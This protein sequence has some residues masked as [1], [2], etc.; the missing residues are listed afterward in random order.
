MSSYTYSQSFTETHAKHLAAKV[1]TD[2]KRMQRFYGSPSDFKIDQFEKEI[3]SFLKSGY[4]E[5]VTYGFKRNNK[6]I[7]PTLKYTAKELANSGV[8]DD[9]G[10]IRPGADISGAFFYSYLSQS[11]AYF[12]ASSDEQDKFNTNLPFQRTGADYPNTDGYFS[13]DRSYF[14][15]GKG[16]DR[17]SLKSF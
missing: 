16:L 8:D 4:L 1:A 17:S 9:P 7:E 6:W 2:L 10:K 15:G 13:N 14:S 12:N 5:H 3:I 11:Q